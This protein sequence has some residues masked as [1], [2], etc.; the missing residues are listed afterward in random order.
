MTEWEDNPCWH[1]CGRGTDVSDFV[2]D[3]IDASG[4]NFAS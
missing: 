1:S 3:G 4:D 2:G